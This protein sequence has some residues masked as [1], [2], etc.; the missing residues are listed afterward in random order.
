[1]ARLINIVR[2]LAASAALFFAFYIKADNRP[3]VSLD[4]VAFGAVGVVGLLSWLGHF[5][6]H[7]QDAQALGW[8]V[9][10]PGFQFEVGFANLAFGLAAILAVLL[11]WGTAAKAT[12]V[13][14]FAIYLGQ[15]CLL[16][17]WNLISEGRVFS[18]RFVRSVLLSGLF[19]AMMAYFAISAMIGM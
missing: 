3:D 14:A 11:D 6:F 8:K 19:V 5:V 1:M 12:A 16:H 2:I 4:I 10:N 18:G 15:A 9:D 13:L 17:A 7:K